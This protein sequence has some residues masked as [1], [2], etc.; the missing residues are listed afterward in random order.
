MLSAN[1]EGSVIDAIFRSLLRVVG[2][3]SGEEYLDLNE[4]NVENVNPCFLACFGNFYENV[5]NYE[6]T[7]QYALSIAQGSERDIKSKIYN[8]LW[9]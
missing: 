5:A 6:D 2:T 8:L 4:P 1:D 7:K 9:D 3:Y